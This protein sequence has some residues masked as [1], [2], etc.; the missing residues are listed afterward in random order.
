MDHSRP[1]TCKDLVEVVTDYLEGALPPA[2]VARFEEHLADCPHCRVYLAQMRLE[3]DA[4]GHLP[5][6]VVSA[7]AIK[8]LLS[9]FRG[10]FSLS[11]SF[12]S[13]L[14]CYCASWCL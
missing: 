11:P 4:L 13:A 1:M 9:R 6:D 5:A 7:D 2:E 8:T 12:A 14:W 10:P 3:I